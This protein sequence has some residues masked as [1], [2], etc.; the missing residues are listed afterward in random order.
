MREI[1]FGGKRIDNGE[2]V[3]GYYVKAVHHWHKYGVHEDWIV[4]KTFS[5]SFF[6]NDFSLAYS[7]YLLYHIL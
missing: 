4:T 2:W 1:L 5:S 6:L 3:E 7:F